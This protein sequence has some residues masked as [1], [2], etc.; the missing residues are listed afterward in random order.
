[1]AGAPL[2]GRFVAHCTGHTL[3]NRLLRALFADKTAWR[4]VALDSV[5]WDAMSV[6]AE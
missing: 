2:Q 1:L 5:A 4:L 6:A 3:N